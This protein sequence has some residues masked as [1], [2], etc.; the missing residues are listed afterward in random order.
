MEDVYADYAW[1]ATDGVVGPLIIEEL[2]NGRTV[3]RVLLAP[4]Q[5]SPS[6]SRVLVLRCAS[7]PYELATD[8]AHLVMLAGFDPPE[9]VN[10]PSQSTSFL[11]FKY[12]AST[13]DDLRDSIPYMGLRQELGGQPQGR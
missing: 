1:S 2:P 6:A 12:P 10:D 9:A 5:G 3:Q 8:S 13:W 4:P 11:A 7:V